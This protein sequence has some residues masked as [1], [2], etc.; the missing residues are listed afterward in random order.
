[1][2]SGIY[3]RLK[4][5]R[6]VTWRSA[7]QHNIYARGEN[8]SVCVETDET[9]IRTYL[10]SFADRA[11]QLFEWLPAKFSYVLRACLHQKLGIKQ[12]GQ[13]LL[14][15]VLE[16]ISH[17][18]QF[19]IP[20]GRQQIDRRP[21]AASTAT[22]QAATDRKSTRL[23]SSHLVISYAVFCLKKKISTFPGIW[24]TTSSQRAL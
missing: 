8:L 2:L 23:N 24:G 18:D 1:M 10:D 11:C 21:G 6:P 22:H 12:T 16:D 7:Q 14:E 19:Y 13:G 9:L 17:A 15:F 3:R 20:V 5:L 4:L